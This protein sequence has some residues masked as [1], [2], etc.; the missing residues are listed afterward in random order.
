MKGKLRFVVGMFL[1]AVLPLGEPLGAQGQGAAAPRIVLEGLDPV[2]LLQGKEVPGKES[3]ALERPPFI[4]I[5][6]SEENKAAFEKEP[7]KYVVQMNGAC[8]RMGPGSR[9]NPDLWGVVDG[10]IYVFASENCKKAFSANPQRYFEPKNEPLKITPESS[11]RAKELLAKAAQAMGGAKLD[12]LENIQFTGTWSGPTGDAEFPQS[13]VYAFPD[14]LRFE[15]SATMQGRPVTMISVVTPADSFVL[16]NQGE[17][18]RTFRMLPTTKAN[19]EKDFKRHPLWI[20]RAR[21]AQDFHAVAEGAVSIAG[22]EA[23]LIA[24]DF[25]GM[26]LKLA[27]DP[28]SGQVLRLSYVERGPDGF[29]LI[30]ETYSEFKTVDGIT[31]PLVSAATYDGKPFARRTFK[32]QSFTVNAALAP[33]LFQRPAPPQQ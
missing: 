4:Y 12:A 15:Q 8:P 29:G 23:Q 14:R 32:S 28:A 22:R 7:E 2:M 33:E 11:G 20:V 9:G 13:M 25:E 19:T 5:F 30:E 16:M 6:A 21:K 18:R 3:I 24:A 31:L 27:V 17:Q 26:R 10:K 1:F